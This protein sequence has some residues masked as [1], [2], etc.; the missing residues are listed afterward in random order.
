MSE[1]G[2]RVRDTYSD[3]SDIA[4]KDLIIEAHLSFPNAAWVSIC[5]WLASSERIKNSRIPHS[6]ANERG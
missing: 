2:M 3:V 1:Y 6:S 5:S 4:L